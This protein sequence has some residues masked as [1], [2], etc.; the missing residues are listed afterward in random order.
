[1]QVERE[2]LPSDSHSNR[3]AFVAFPR[4]KHSPSGVVHVHPYSWLRG[5]IKVVFFFVLVTLAA[6][7]Q[8][9]SVT[10]QWSGLMTWPSTS[11]GWVPTHGML[12]P[13]GKGLYYSSYGDGLNPH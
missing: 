6:A 12:L 8:D 13:N 10:G 1:M 7:A 2:T 4:P 5:S 3:K 9:P 11:V